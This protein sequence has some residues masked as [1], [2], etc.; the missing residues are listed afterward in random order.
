MKNWLLFVA[1]IWPNIASAV[2]QPPFLPL[3]NVPDYVATISVKLSHGPTSRE[4]RTFHGGWT[5]VDGNFDRTAYRSTTYVGPGGLFVTFAREPSAQVEGHDWLHVM[6][7]TLIRWGD[8]PFKTGERQTFLGEACEVWNLSKDLVHRDARGLS[9]VTP[10]GIELWSRI[11]NAPGDSFE[12]TAMVRK[13][14]DPDEVRPPAERLDLKSWL[15]TANGVARPSDSP[16]DVTVVMQSRTKANPHERVVTRTIRR[17]YP[18][19]YTEDV[20]AKGERKIT[21]KNEAERL[22]I[23]FRSDAMGEPLQ[24][25]ITK[26]LRAFAYQKLPDSGRNETILGETCVVSERKFRHGYS[27][28]CHTA[29][30]VM[31]KDESG[32]WGEMYDL[33]AVK[34]DRAP[35]DLEAVLPPSRIFARAAWGIPD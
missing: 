21:F 25:S 32:D 6:R 2:A 8:N 5:R 18:W 34:L 35:V 9:C 11:E 3:P 28:Q 20:Y 26:A 30:G 29:D 4:I 13:P 15:T 27:N 31:L 19:T 10:D 17:H 14:V 33:V 1:L 12:T 7:R 16:G 23:V 22:S 24:L